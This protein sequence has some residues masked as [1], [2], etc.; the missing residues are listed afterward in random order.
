MDT[1]NQQVLK[2]AGLE[3]RSYTLTIDDVEVG[4]FNHEELA[5]GINLAKSKTPMS[6]QAAAVHALTLQRNQIQ[7]FHWRELVVRFQEES[8]PVVLETRAAMAK[9]E[10]ELLRRQ[11][12]TAIPKAHR[13][14][15]LPASSVQANP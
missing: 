5:N 11:R 15:L 7:F 10:A 9:L 13:F 12:E 2:V 4:K 6:K 1:L 3:P 8:T 14:A